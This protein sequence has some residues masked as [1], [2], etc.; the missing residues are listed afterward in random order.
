MLKIEGDV[1]RRDS[2]SSDG[3]CLGEISWKPE[4][5]NHESESNRH[6]CGYYILFDE[7]YCLKQ[8]LEVTFGN[9][10]IR[11]GSATVVLKLTSVGSKARSSKLHE[12]SKCLSQNLLSVWK[13]AKVERWQSSVRLGVKYWTQTRR[14]TR[15]GRV[16]QFE[17]SGW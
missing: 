6:M 5:S 13:A 3:E 1:R 2:S 10:G 7:F 15:R 8:I 11:S 16:V 17:L 9:A 12:F 14:L 4:W